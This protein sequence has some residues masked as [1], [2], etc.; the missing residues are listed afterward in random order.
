MINRVFGRRGRKKT[1]RAVDGTELEVKEGEILDGAGKVLA[2]REKNTGAR[3]GVAKG[4][5]F[6]FRGG[7]LPSLAFAVIGIPLVIFAGFWILVV[8]V[9][10][11]LAML[12]FGR[13][14]FRIVRIT[15]GRRP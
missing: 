14:L 13:S 3:D 6:V 15:G 7:L 12:V 4:R 9:T 5:F 2:G 10:G 8:A 11:F 1:I